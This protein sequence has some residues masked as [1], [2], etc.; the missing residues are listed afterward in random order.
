MLRQSRIQYPGA[1]CHVTSR[2]N[3]RRESEELVRLGW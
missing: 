3:R 2:G 1:V